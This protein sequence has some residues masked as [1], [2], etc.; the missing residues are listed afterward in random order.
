MLRRVRTWLTNPPVADPVDRRNAPMFQVVMLLL[1]TAPPLLWGYRVSLLREIPWR[2]GET[3]SLLSSLV[4]CGT[5]A[6]AFV[7]VRRG[8]F[9]WAVRQVLATV[10]V[11]MLAAYATAGM[12]SQMF[13]VPL[14]L[15]WLFVSGTMVGRRAL[16]AMFLVLCTALFLGAAS[17]LNAGR[18]DHN[19]FGD[20]L[21]RSVMFLLIAIV[22]DRSS[23]ALRGSL[24]EATARGTALAAANA[25]L[26][27]EIEARER[28]REQL[29]HAQ[30]VEAVGRMASGVAHD[31]NHL[32]G[33]VL[34]YAARGRAAASGRAD[35]EEAFAGVESAARRGVAVA[36]K[37]TSFSRREVA[38]VD[39]FDAGD[40]VR[41][42]L[43]MLRQ[44]LGAGIV[45][46]AE[47]ADAPLPV[48]FDRAQLELVLL[49]L[50]A[51]AAHAMPDGGRAMLALQARDGAMHLAL[52]DTG[53]GMAADVAARALE[54]FFT[55]KP[56]GQGTGLGLAVAA[57]LLGDA[58]G[59]IRLETAPGA[60]TTVH[61]TLPLAPDDAAVQP[62]PGYQVSA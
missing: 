46:A 31:F 9:Q 14:Q 62:A 56:A 11:A 59:G 40:A 18:I 48:R 3:W 29:L 27:D 49:N 23:S 25:Q 20:A 16:W 60:G 39:R 53:H 24:A 12:G 37:L 2:E 52:S 38:R 47:I 10:A 4:V 34:G 42:M 50:A 54:P 5:A 35:I 45:L 57:D 13:E 58:G 43:P 7:L 6:F 41:E 36:G 55:T 51:N 33:L 19:V 44:T 61:L 22:I 17:D 28:I 15:M 1:A 8:R 21:I 26:R 32:L 30:R